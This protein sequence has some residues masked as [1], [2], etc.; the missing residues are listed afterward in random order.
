MSRRSHAFLVLGAL[1]ALSGLSG[2]S[3]FR[4]ISTCRSLA[5][6]TNP[7]LDQ[8]DALASKPAGDQ[9]ARADQ[10]ARM[11]GLY[12]ELAKRLKPHAAGPSTLAAA[13]KDYAGI[14]EATSKA[15]KNQ[16]DATRSGTFGRTTELRRELERL[17]KRERSAVT[18]LETECHS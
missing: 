18:R 9:Q 5:R 13:I 3:R 6:E 10:Q 15:L 7:T 2:C 1:L 8:I 12:A 16:A 14:L 17:V 4:E 11:A